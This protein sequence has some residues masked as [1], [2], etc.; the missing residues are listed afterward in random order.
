MW[1]KPF[2]ELL[3]NR[4]F[5]HY[6]ADTVLMLLARGLWIVSGF[7]VTIYIARALGVEL[8]GELCYAL[9]FASIFISLASMNVEKLVVCK[10]ID[11]PEQRDKVLGSFFLFRLVSCT[12]VLGVLVVLLAFTDLGKA[13]KILCFLCACPCLFNSLEGIPAY[14]KAI[15]RNA[16][17]AYYQ[18]LAC[19]VYSGVRL[20]VAY[21]GL[22]L[23]YYALGELLLTAVPAFYLLTVYWRRV[24]SPWRWTLDFGL[25]RGLFL[26]ALPL[27]LY[28]FFSLLYFR[29]DVLLLRLY[30]GEI[31]VGNYSIG[32]RI[33]ENW[34][35]LGEA[36]INVLFPL[37]L[38]KTLGSRSEFTYSYRLFMRILFYLMCVICVATMLLSRPLLALLFGEEY[39]PAAEAINIYIW[40]LPWLVSTQILAYCV[41]KEGHLAQIAAVMLSSVLLNCVLNVYVIP[42]YGMIGAAVVFALSIPM[43]LVLCLCCTKYGREQLGHFAVSLLFMPL[44]R[45]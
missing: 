44:R 5:R 35:L 24:G 33:T 3:R 2:K 26:E 12:V 10:L 11:S 29:L 14:F 23:I 7:V 27:S 30:S 13:S 25:A 20:Y 16:P 40:G 6:S 1:K 39:L 32:V 9:A 18:L 42:Y 19:A 22:P 43:S 28:A 41:A 38:V 34:N 17:V 15:G 8:F 45:R 4:D 37:L 36:L 31:A 21:T